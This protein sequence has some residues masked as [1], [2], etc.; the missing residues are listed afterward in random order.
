MDVVDMLVVIS[1]KGEISGFDHFLIARRR[2]RNMFNFDAAAGLLTAICI[3]AQAV[4][5]SV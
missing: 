2:A 4:E 3:V 1:L 5:G